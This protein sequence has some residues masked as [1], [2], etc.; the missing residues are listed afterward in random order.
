MGAQQAAQPSVL[1]EVSSLIQTLSILVGVVISILSFNHTRRKE[2]EARKVEAAR[3]FLLLRQSTYIEALKVAAIL[4]NQDA[5]TEEEISVA[6]RR[7]RDLYVAELSMVEPPEV[8]QQMVALAGQIAPDLLD[9]SPAQGA[10][11][12]LAHALRNSFTEAYDLSPSPR[13]GL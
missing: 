2:A 13:A 8:E 1:Q 12:R 11:L 9:L 3:P 10:A 6:K 4:A 5:H 7:F